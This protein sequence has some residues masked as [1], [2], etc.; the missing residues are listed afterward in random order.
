MFLVLIVC[1]QEKSKLVI[2][3]E[4]LKIYNMKIDLNADLGESFGNFKMGNDAEIIKYVTSASIACGF[5]GGDPLTIQNT[6]KLALEHN[7]SIGA[8]PGYDD[9]KGFGRRSIKISDEDLYAMILYQ[10]GALKAITNALGGKLYHVKPHGALYNDLANSLPKAKIVAEAIYKIDPEL[11]FV[12]LSNSEIQH[13]AREIGLKSACEVFADRAYNDDGS[14]V[15]RHRYGAVFGD[16]EACMNQ[17][18]QIIKE[19]SVTSINGN[20]VDMCVDTIGIQADNQS[21]I[22]FAENFHQYLKQEKIQL[23]SFLK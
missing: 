23:K 6:V 4:S 19:K 5:H 21:A 8:H 12:G 18:K 22:N 17:V 16:G 10:V 7:V 11:I 9:L 3:L 2:K 13:A 1:V 14:L 20:S 15:A